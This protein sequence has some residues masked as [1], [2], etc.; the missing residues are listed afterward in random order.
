MGK[1]NVYDKLM[2]ENHKQIETIEYIF[3]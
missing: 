3:T 2:I 1:S